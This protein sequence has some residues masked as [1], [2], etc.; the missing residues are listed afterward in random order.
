MV[1]LVLAQGP[2]TEVP[3]TVYKTT[4]HVRFGAISFFILFFL[5]YC[6]IILDYSPYYSVIS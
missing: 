1:A 3:T 2:R 4:E 5:L 6:M